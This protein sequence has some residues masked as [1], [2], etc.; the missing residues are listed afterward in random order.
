MEITALS[1][2]PARAVNESAARAS[3][4]ALQQPSGRATEKLITTDLWPHGLTAQGREMRACALPSRVDARGRAIGATLADLIEQE[5]ISALKQ[6]S[7]RAEIAVAVNGRPVARAAWRETPLKGGEIVTLRAAL[8]DGGGDKNPLRTILQIGVLVA[9]IVVPPLL[10]TATWAQTLA[11]AAITIAGGLIVNAIAPPILPDTARP[12]AIEPI[13]S[14]SGGANRARA[15]EPLLL[16]LGAHRVFPDLGAAEYTE[17]SGDDH[18]LHQIFNFGLGDLAVDDLRIGTTALDSYE[19]VETEF[20]DA[21]GRIALVAGNVDSIA[22]GV[23][24]DTQWLERT[25]AAGT[26][27]IGVDIT[28][29]LFRI[30]DEGEIQAN[31]AEIEIEWRAPGQATQRRTITLMHD[32]QAPL[33]RTFAYDLAAAGAWTVRVRRTADPDPSD[34]VHDELAW[35]ALRAYQIDDG[36]YSGQTRLG[37]RIRAT[38]QLSRPPRPS[39]RHGAPARADVGRRPLDRACRDLQSGLAVPLVCAG[40]AYRRPP[41][42]RRRLA[43]YAHRRGFDQGLG[44]MVRGPGARLQSRA[45]PHP[46]PCRGADHD[47]PMRPREP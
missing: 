6:R 17:I 38:G 36:D 20:G 28:G 44:R 4:I 7:G 5:W 45:R 21:R 42:R 23:L 24:D 40:P 2:A 34:R 16:V 3:D 13:Y 12:R 26:R 43:R 19:E 32:S 46:L 31:S 14:L 41:G 27:R 39:L 11:G 30:D 8:A 37:L 1:R 29:R 25:T 10:F 18:V 9:A 22:G 47:R 33:R 15:Y 35:A